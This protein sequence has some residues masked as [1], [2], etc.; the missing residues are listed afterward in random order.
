MTDHTNPGTTNPANDV[1]GLGLTKNVGPAVGLPGK[2]VPI[3]QPGPGPIVNL[4]SSSGETGATGPAGGRGATGATGVGT[5]G[6]TGLTGAGTTGA[7]GPTGAGTTGA[8]GPTGA[9]T[10]GATGPTGAGTTGATGLTGAGTT[11]ATGLSGEGGATGATG[12]GGGGGATG[13]TGPAGMVVVKLPTVV[14]VGQLTGGV[15]SVRATDSSL[16]ITATAST[17]VQIDFLA[18][19]AGSALSVTDSGRNCPNCAITLLPNGSDTIDGAASFVMNEFAGQSLTL[20]YCV[21]TTN[22]E[23]V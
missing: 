4:P 15:Y 11:G 1:V 6:A 7:T 9:G 5:T 18:G 12:P 17:A 20:A 8:T 13:A 2:G 3:V 10:T 22:W 14:G 16:Q 19:S 21:P 23:I